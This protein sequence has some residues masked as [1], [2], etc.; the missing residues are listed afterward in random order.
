[1]KKIKGFTGL[2]SMLKALLKKKALPPSLIPLDVD[3]SINVDHLPK[4]TT[5]L[6]G[7][8]T[9]LAQLTEAF[10]NPNIRL[11]II[12]AAGGIGKSALTDEWLQ[13]IGTVILKTAVGT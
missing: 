4:P 11:A 6:I 9:E 5:A 13:Q 10:T 7:R 2:W 12:V 8:K 3:F 1:M